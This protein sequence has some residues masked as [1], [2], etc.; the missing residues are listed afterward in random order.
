MAVVVL[1][2]MVAGLAAACR[3][4]SDAEE[5]GPITVLTAAAETATAEA[6]AIRTPEAETTP[7]L[8]TPAEVVAA[9]PVAPAETVAPQASQPP[10]PKPPATA[11]TSGKWIDIDVTRLAVRLMDGASALSTIAPVGVGA[12]VDTGIYNSTATGL[13]YVYSKTAD[14]TYDAPYDTY[15]SDWV[16]FDPALDNGFHSFLKDKDGKVVDASTGRIS[17]G[18]IRTGDS[19]AI[20]A[21]AQ[22]GMPVF[23]HW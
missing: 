17:N 18:C 20:F 6:E 22:I 12:Q 10:A 5:V 9:T 4:G 19:G 2:V 13:F 1:T 14:L 16:G 15:I 3:G 11:P 23:V 7:T 8:A 21:F